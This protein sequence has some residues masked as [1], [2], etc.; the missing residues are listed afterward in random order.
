M[1]ID[2]MKNSHPPRMNKL[3]AQYL[4]IME[5]LLG[6]EAYPNKRTG[7]YTKSTFFKTIQHDMREGFPLLTSR[8]V[9]YK[10][11]FVELEGFMKG[12]TSKR[13]Y[14]ERGCPF[15]DPFAAPYKVEYGHDED[16]RKAMRE[17][18]DL[19][20]IYGA[21][22]RSFNDEGHDQLLNVVEKIKMG[23]DDRRLIVTAWNPVAL[24]KQA[25][26]P[27]HWSFIIHLSP[28]GEFLD[29]QWNQRSV[30]FPLGNALP[31]YGL[32]IEL[33]AREAKR[34]ARNLIGVYSNVHLYDNQW[35]TC[36][37]HLSRSTFE[38]LPTLELSNP[39]FFEFEAACHAKIKNYEHAGELKYPYM[40]I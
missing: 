21:Q 12:I 15:W 33:L 19:G 13:W 7:T 24:E 22:W 36:E 35:D 5:E 11:E 2:T 31:K 28:C 40:V 39:S 9:P 32:L 6:L 10:G 17:E 27:C 38:T 4:G 16:A 23:E 20:P 1:E 25:L 30:D 37:E 34:T 29:L 8:R 3:D 18:D 26:P 14:Q